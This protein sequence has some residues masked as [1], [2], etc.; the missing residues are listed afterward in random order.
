MNVIKYESQHSFTLK[1]DRVQKKIGQMYL[2]TRMADVHFVFG[3]DTESREE[4]PAHKI[5]LSLQN[6]VFDAMFFGPLKVDAKVP[7]DHT[8]ASAF[9]D[10]LQ[11]FYKSQVTLTS[12]NVDK[13][14]D[15]CKMY[16]MNDCLNV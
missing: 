12:E 9:K 6:D 1:N 11:F 13:V 4:V 2:N 5:I 10:F 14:L 16:E 3:A 15:L 8:S 7:I